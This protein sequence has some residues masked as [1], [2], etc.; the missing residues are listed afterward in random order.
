MRPWSRAPWL[1]RSIG[2]RPNRRRSAICRRLISRTPHRGSQWP[3]ADVL[4]AR[5]VRWFHNPAEP[6]DSQTP[7]WPKHS[8]TSI[9]V[10]SG[11]ISPR[12]ASVE[13]LLA[14]PPREHFRRGVGHGQ[15]HAVAAR[16]DPAA[17]AERGFHLALVGPHPNE[18]MFGRQQH[19]MVEFVE[20]AAQRSR[21]AI[22]STT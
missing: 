12:A 20:D 1:L 7:N 8:S 15:Q 21:R 5:G 3:A 19:V 4:S 2:K 9:R 22:K 16:K 14:D 13:Q 18:R 11:R 10:R 6:L 17:I